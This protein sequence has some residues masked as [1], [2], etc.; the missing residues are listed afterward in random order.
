MVVHRVALASVVLE[1]AGAV[2]CTTVRRID[3]VRFFAQ[4]SP[5]V[6]WVTYH[7]N[8]V[9]P[10]AQAD[11]AGDTLKGVKQGTQDPVWIPLDQVRKVSAK[12]PDSRKTALLVTGALAGL[13]GSVYLL[14]IS[15]AGPRPAGISCGFNEDGIAIQYC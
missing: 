14:W 15:K 1:V 10:I 4:N 8:T 3:P 7:D 12:I 5:D 9:V 13:A 11:L 2:A 6:V